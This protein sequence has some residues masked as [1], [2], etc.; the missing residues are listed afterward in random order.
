[1]TAISDEGD[2]YRVRVP[3]FALNEQTCVLIIKKQK[4]EILAFWQASDYK[5]SFDGKFPRRSIEE[6]RELK[7][8]WP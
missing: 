7:K 5:E 4:G 8:F 6:W 1:M 2:Y 3:V